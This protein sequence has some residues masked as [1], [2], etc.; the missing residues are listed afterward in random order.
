MEV[1]GTLAGGIAHDFNNILYVIG[2][3]ELAEEDVPEGSLARAN[4]EEAFKAIIRAKDLVQQILTFSRQVEPEGKPLQIH[5][6]VKEALKLLRSSLPTTI[7]I[8]QNINTESGAVLA[9]QVQIYQLIMNLCTNAYHSMRDNGGVLEVSLGEVDLDSGA[10]AHRPDL[11]SGPY[12]KLTVSDTGHGMDSVVMERIFEPYFTT[13]E[14]GKGTWMGLSVVHGIV[15]SHGGYI[16]VDSELGK[17]TTLDVYLPRMDT[18]AT[19]PETVSSEPAPRGDERILLVD[20]E[21]QVVNMVRQML[22]RLGYHV[23][24]RTSSVEVLEASRAQPEKFDLVITDQTMPNMTGA[25]LT[26]KLIDIRADVPIILCTGFSE[27]ISEEKAKEIGIS[28]YVMKP[29]V[30]SEIGKTI[31]KMLDK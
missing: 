2:N 10:V 14:P 15:T 9:D 8:R 31:R 28:E 25:E 5:P 20:D 22:E 6:I 3:A 4:L 12:L 30:Q 7:E 1:I 21:E 19:A 18:P 24:A 26:K 27:V 23:T 13:K 29:V 17:G 16:P 11:T